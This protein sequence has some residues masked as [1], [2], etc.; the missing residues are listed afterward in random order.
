M[1]SEVL[2]LSTEIKKQSHRK[3]T[4]LKNWSYLTIH[5]IFSF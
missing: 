3:I 5:I 4:Q 1:S 2:P